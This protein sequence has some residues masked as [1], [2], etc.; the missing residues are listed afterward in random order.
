[1]SD[2]MARRVAHRD[3]HASRYR[4]GSRERAPSISLLAS[5]RVIATLD[6]DLGKSSRTNLAQTLWLQDAPRRRIVGKAVRSP[7]PIQALGARIQRFWLEQ[8][9]SARF[10]QIA[11]S[12]F[13]ANGGSTCASAVM[14]AAPCSFGSPR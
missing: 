5:E 11:G 1:V 8:N 14:T 4:G 6:P 10:S 12:E 7:R 3:A 9:R 2:Q 13:V